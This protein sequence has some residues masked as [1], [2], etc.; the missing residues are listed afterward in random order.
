MLRLVLIFV[1]A[2]IAARAFW[3]LVDGVVDGF[4]ERAPGGAVPQRG[5]HMARDPVC[6]TYVIPNPALALGDGSRQVFF[7]SARCRD[8]YRPSTSSG[9]PEPVEGRAS[10]S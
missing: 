7:C 4:R 6:G 10:T 3:R 9:R 2:A 1:L 5:V 8:Q